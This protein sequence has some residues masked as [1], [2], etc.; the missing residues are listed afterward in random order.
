MFTASRFIWSSIFPLKDT[1]VVT[2]T[3]IL[4]KGQK[5]GLSVGENLKIFNLN[6][7]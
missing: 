7:K 2:I 1:T 4:G 5:K 3:G 6:L